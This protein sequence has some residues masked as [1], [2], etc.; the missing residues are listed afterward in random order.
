MLKV[1]HEKQA[2]NLFSVVGEGWEQWQCHFIPFSFF[3]VKTLSWLAVWE[4]K[5]PNL[6]RTWISVPKYM[7]RV[8]DWILN[9]S[10]QV[11]FSIL[12]IQMTKIW[13]DALNTQKWKGTL[14]SP[15]FCQREFSSLVSWLCLNT[16]AICKLQDICSIL[17]VLFKTADVTEHLF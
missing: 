10:H 16:V 8:S 11:S 2:L 6:P 7:F 14:P 5:D 4:Y 13:F 9:T 1:Y 3:P 12:K 15:L 17:V